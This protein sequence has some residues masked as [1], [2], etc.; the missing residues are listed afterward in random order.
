M[1]LCSL[2]AS[3][4]SKCSGSKCPQEWSRPTRAEGSSAFEWRAMREWQDTATGQPQAAPA[5]DRW[6]ERHLTAQ[7]RGL[8]WSW[9]GPQ[10]LWQNNHTWGPK[11]AA[12][13]V[14]PS[15]SKVMLRRG[16]PQG[17]QEERHVGM[18]WVPAS[19]KEK[20]FQ[21][22]G[23]TKEGEAG[24]RCLFPRH[25]VSADS[26]N[27]H[28]VPRAPH[29]SC[30]ES[31]ASQL[32]E[33]CSGFCIPSLREGSPVSPARSRA[34]S[35]SKIRRGPLAGWAANFSLQPHRLER[36]LASSLA[37]TY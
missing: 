16:A 27:P 21:A 15:P 22:E 11:P 26:E 4:C 13:L 14:D 23:G 9:A 24:R 3:K 35:A 10:R 33:A 28:W 17:T 19:C 2:P 18:A 5:W 8:G 12:D 34:H 6:A 31:K 25:P 7:K 37:S 36:Q 1:S 29:L 20:S 32:L 30:S